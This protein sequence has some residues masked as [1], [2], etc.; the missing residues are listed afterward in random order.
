MQLHIKR[1]EI[2]WISK[3]YLVD[4]R[5]RRL[6]ERHQLF[7][8]LP[9]FF[10]FGSSSHWIIYLINGLLYDINSLDGL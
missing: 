3:R 1:R 8:W 9:F 7:K 4:L 5:G 10:F 6:T 2:W